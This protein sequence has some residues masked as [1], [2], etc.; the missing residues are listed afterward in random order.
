MMIIGLIAVLFTLSI[1][2]IMVDRNSSKMNLVPVRVKSTDIKNKLEIAD[3]D[4]LKRLG[5][6]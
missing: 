1:I 3:R 5:M 6:M 2:L 4:E